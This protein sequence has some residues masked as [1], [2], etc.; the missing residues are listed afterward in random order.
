MW[1]FNNNK[2]VYMQI[3]DVIMSRISSGE[4][5]PGSRL[6]SVRELAAEARVNPN[7]MQ[8]AL[9]EIERN[10]F[11]CSQRTAGKFVTNNNELVQSEN[12]KRARDLAVYIVSEL[13]KINMSVDDIVPLL[14]EHE[15][16][17]E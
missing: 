13:R 7:T 10:G 11:I 12:R 8:R 4:Y 16:K 14:K 1:E 15:L 5:P 3:V 17:G 6:P 9:A 2:P